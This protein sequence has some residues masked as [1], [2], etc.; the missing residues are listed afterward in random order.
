MLAAESGS[1]RSTS[2]VPIPKQWYYDRRLMSTEF[3]LNKQAARIWCSVCFVKCLYKMLSVVH[4]IR[5]ICSCYKLVHNKRYDAYQKTKKYDTKTDNETWVYLHTKHYRCF[6]H[7]SNVTFGRISWSELRR[8]SSH[9]KMVFISV[10]L[11]CLLTWSRQTNITSNCKSTNFGHI[12]FEVSAYFLWNRTLDGIWIC[13][14][15]NQILW[16]IRYLFLGGEII[17]CNQ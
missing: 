11:V 17:T 10:I 13:L 9:I 12:P 7:L 2:Y 4:E 6:N 8:V 5:Q 3:I 1:V 15:C 16:L 14:D